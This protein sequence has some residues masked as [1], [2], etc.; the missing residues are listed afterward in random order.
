MINTCANASSAKSIDSSA[1][2]VVVATKNTDPTTATTTI[3]KRQP[4]AKS[5]DLCLR[6]VVLYDRA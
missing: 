6:V 1:E 3:D 5:S 4:H 2:Q